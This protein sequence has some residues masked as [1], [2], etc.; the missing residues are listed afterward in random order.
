MA[1][2]ALC[3]PTYAE[4]TLRIL[5]FFRFHAAYGHGGQPDAAGLAACIAARAGL[6]TLSR[7]RVRMEIDVRVCYC[8]VLGDC[9]KVS[10][11]TDDE[12]PTPL[13]SCADERKRPQYR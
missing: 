11:L 7:E 10:S 9:W 5:R 6:Q 12:D 1:W 13:S 8:S 2:D 4:Q 3:S